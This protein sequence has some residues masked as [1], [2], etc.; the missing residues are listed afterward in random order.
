MA[1][2]ALTHGGDALVLIG[3][4]SGHLGRSMLLRV[5]TGRD[6]GTPPPVNLAAERRN[7]DFVRRL[8]ADG[9]VTACHD[10]SDGGL[11]IAV[12]EMALAGGIGARLFTPETRLPPLA[13]MFGED[14]ARYVLA[15]A[16]ARPVL[17]AAAEA[18]VS[19]VVAGETGGEEL[20][21]GDGDFIPLQN[22]RDA[23]E[24]WFPARMT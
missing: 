12:A 13:W 4:T 5:L 16:D 2:P 21:V 7:G 19:A 10:I 17:A 6:E 1:R 23:H 9:A 14:Q 22:L 15:A 11:L 18:G 8:I 24:R 20:T 3:D